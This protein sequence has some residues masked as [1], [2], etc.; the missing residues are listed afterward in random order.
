M[1]LEVVFCSSRF[2]D[3]DGRPFFVLCS[4]PNGWPWVRMGAND[5]E[6]VPV[7]GVEVD[8]FETCRFGGI[9]RSGLEARPFLTSRGVLGSVLRLLVKYTLMIINI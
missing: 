7:T 8:N 6:A 2:G 3:D 4:D 5:A 9:S 1:E